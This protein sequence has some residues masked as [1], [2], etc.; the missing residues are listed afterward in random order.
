MLLNKSD[1]ED[2][3]TVG[4]PRSRDEPMWCCCLLLVIKLEFI[5][6]SAGRAGGSDGCVMVDDG[7]CG[8][9]GEELLEEDE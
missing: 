3:E 8:G 2:D 7:D 5:G 1:E 4:Q 6:V 9:G